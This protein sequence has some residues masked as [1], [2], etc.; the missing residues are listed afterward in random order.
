MRSKKPEEEFKPAKRYECGGCGGV[1]TIP[2]GKDAFATVRKI[3]CC[4]KPDLTLLSTEYTDAEWKE[5][6]DKFK[7]P[8][9][10]DSI[11]QELSKDQCVD[12]VIKYLSDEGI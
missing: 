7:N 3:K 11:T 9:L 10:M 6:I 5:L 12:V 4:K 1:I 8:S 2:K